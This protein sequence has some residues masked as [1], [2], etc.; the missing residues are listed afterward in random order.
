VVGVTI[1]FTTPKDVPVEDPMWT[2]AKAVIQGKYNVAREDVNELVDPNHIRLSTT[3][4]TKCP[5]GKKLSG[6]GWED[7]I[8]FD[9]VTLTGHRQIDNDR[10]DITFEM[11]NVSAVNENFPQFAEITNAW[12]Q[13]HVCP[14]ECL[15]QWGQP[16]SAQLIMRSTELFMGVTTNGTNLKVE[17]FNN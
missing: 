7:S 13:T 6:L 4:T 17:N 2:Y 16:R 1:S 5:T 9:P 8:C 14:A 10:I 3:S 11:C 15:D 12:C